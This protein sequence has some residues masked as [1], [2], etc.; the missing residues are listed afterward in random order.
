MPR[1]PLPESLPTPKDALAGFAGLND[2]DDEN[3]GFADPEEER[4]Q[5]TRWAQ[6]ERAPA[7]GPVKGFGPAYRSSAQSRGYGDV[8]IWPRA[9]EHTD[10]VLKVSRVSQHTGGLEELGYMDK[11]ATAYHLV[12]KYRKPGSYHILPTTRAATALEPAPFVLEIGRD[13]EAFQRLKEEEAEATSVGATPSFVPMG[14]SGTPVEVFRILDKSLSATHEEALAARRAQNEA[15]ERLIAQQERLTG[16]AFETTMD[17]FNKLADKST[18]Q[19]DRALSLHASLLEKGVALQLEALK[20]AEKARE[21]EVK[22]R[23]ESAAK[24]QA[25]IIDFLKAERERDVKSAEGQN[26]AM[27]QFFGLQAQVQA[28]QMELSRQRLE[29]EREQIRADRE[30]AERDAERRLQEIESRAEREEAA[31]RDREE[32]EERRAAAERA[33]RDARLEREEERRLK[34]EAHLEKLRQE[35]MA[36]RREQLKSS[37]TGAGANNLLETV[38]TIARVIPTLRDVMGGGADSKAEDED[39]SGP[40]WKHLGGMALQGMTAMMNA[41]TEQA[42]ML[43]QMQQGGPA[44]Y[45]PD[46]G[47]PEEEEEEEEDAPEV[48]YTPPPPPPVDRRLNVGVGT[49]TVSAAPQVNNRPEPDLNTKAAARRMIKELVKELKGFPRPFNADAVQ[50]HVI[51][52]VASDFNVMNSFH[53]YCT[54]KGLRAALAE[55]QADTALAQAVVAGVKNYSGPGAEIVK[56]IPE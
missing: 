39:S 31:R 8:R 47:D 44:G 19:S 10:A 51:S 12:A 46:G 23:E 32:R 13:H 33:E 16:S 35:E 45:L 55:A 40:W 7:G 52:R 28:Q 4:Q 56:E 37:S 20:A 25:M 18:E 1:H 34:H 11:D 17:R 2:D 26:T 14:A 41:R 54:W 53:A 43:M 15:T 50:E 3:Q 42:K 24:Q 49:T 29:L 9:S 30:R 27:A 36:W 5:P 48:V 6:F 21:A 22:A 38:T